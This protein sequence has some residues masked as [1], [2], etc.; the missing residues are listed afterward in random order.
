MYMTTL[1]DNIKFKIKSNIG[2][3]H[4]T[5][6]C[7]LFLFF[8]YLGEEQLTILYS[9]YLSFSMEENSRFQG[10]LKGSSPPQLYTL[11]IAYIYK[12]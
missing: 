8:I 7:C 11:Y 12:N 2:G 3:Y 10:E 4:Y 6:S 1:M 9:Y 5:M